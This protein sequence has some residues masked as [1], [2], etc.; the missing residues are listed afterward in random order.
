M[1]K[2]FRKINRKSK[3]KGFTHQNFQKKISGG[4]TLVETLVAITI[5]SLTVVATMSF[6]SQ[7][8]PNTEYAK[9][10]IIAIYLSQ[11]GIEYIRNMRDNYVLFTGSTSLDWNSFLNK[12][13]PCNVSDNCGINV[14]VSSSDPN[15]IFL[16]SLDPNQC[17][18]YLY[19]G[20]YNVNANGVDSGFTRKIQIDQINSNE[21]KITSTVSWNQI[22]KT[23]NITLSEV[24]FNWI[25]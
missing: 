2:F 10:K 3:M 13:S 4:F 20:D 15:S 17:K 5:F 19:N 23:Y 18:L 14:S 1:E 7:N 9:N 16:C 8:I 12:V 21:I 25:E 11:E 6:M 24:L 22:G